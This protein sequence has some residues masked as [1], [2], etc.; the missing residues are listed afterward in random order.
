MDD[1]TSIDSAVMTLAVKNSDPNFPSSRW[2]FSWKKYVT[3]ELVKVLVKVNHQV[4]S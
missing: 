1:A 4:L 2:N 3:Q